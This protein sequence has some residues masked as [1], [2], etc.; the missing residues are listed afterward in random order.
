MGILGW[1][2][3]NATVEVDDFESKVLDELDRQG[4]IEDVQLHPK[5][6]SKVECITRSDKVTV[7][8]WLASEK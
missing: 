6:F 3:T 1:F 4:L 2:G 7:E 5:A 8:R